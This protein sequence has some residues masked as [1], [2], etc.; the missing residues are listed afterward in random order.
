MPRRCSSK[1]KRI[2]TGVASGPPRCKG[3]I[4]FFL[5]FFFF[6]VLCKTHIFET[7]VNF[8]LSSNF[9]YSFIYFIFLIH[10]CR[11]PTEK[12]RGYFYRLIFSLFKLQNLNLVFDISL[13][14]RCL[15]FLK[16]CINMYS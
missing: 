7:E 2:K 16:L 10:D 15:I 11:M 4:L 8:F 3:P 6:N 13:I 14:R 12:I 5:F 9:I 1:Y